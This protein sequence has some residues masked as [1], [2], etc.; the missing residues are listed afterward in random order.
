VRRFGGQHHM[1]FI[2]ELKQPSASRV[3]AASNVDADDG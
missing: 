1:I 2:A 3:R